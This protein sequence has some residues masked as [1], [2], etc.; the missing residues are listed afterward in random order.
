MKFNDGYWL[1]REGVTARYATEALDVRAGEDS[2]SIAVLTRP[3]EHID[4]VALLQKTRR[5]AAAA[6]DGAEPVGSL[7]KTSVDQ[8]HWK[9]MPNFP[10]NPVLDIHLHAVADG[11]A[12][13]QRVLDAVPVVG[14]LGD[15]Q[16]GI[17]RLPAQL[18]RGSQGGC[19]I[20]EFAAGHHARRYLLKCSRVRCQASSAAALS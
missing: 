17:G 10:G 16:H 8:H 14:P 11:T 2:A 4:L 15:V 5:P 1:L 18:G 19:Q 20:P 3:V 6:I 12:G 9:R 13:E 7:P